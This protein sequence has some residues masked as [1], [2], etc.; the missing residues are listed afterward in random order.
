MEF[1]GHNEN[2]GHIPFIPGVLT[3]G[4]IVNL[5]PICMIC[6]MK[7]FMNREQIRFLIGQKIVTGTMPGIKTMLK[8][9]LTIHALCKPWSWIRTYFPNAICLKW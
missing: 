2:Q 6:P 8:S 3:K 9:Q 5:L 4:W 1:R 7:L